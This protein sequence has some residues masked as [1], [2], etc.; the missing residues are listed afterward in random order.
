MITAALVGAETSRDDNPHLPLTAREIGV[1]A[2]KACAA[3]ASMIHLHVRDGAGNPTQDTEAFRPA[4]AEIKSRCDAIIQVSTGGA[5]GM[6]GDE[7]CRPLELR[8]EMC[9][10]TA[11]SVNFGDE[12]FLN[13]RPLMIRIAELARRRGV[14]PELEIFDAG[15]MDNALWLAKKGHIDLPAH[16]D[17]VLGVPGGLGADAPALDFLISRLPPGCTWSAAGIGRAE[18]PLAEMAVSRGGHVRVGLEDNIFIDKGVLAEGNAP[19]VA[20]AAR[21]AAAAGRAVMTPSEARKMLG[22]AG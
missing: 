3:G 16:F 20:K 21:I 14:K 2:E 7:R 11:G 9:T 4:I 5:V 10:L 6:T 13:P 18:F 17:F 12:V 15:F 19:L 8:P 22:L 1:E